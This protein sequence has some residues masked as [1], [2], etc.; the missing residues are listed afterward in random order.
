MEKKS[1]DSLKKEPKAIHRPK[2]L[3]IS[4]IDEISLDAKVKLLQWSTIFHTHKQT[5][6]QTM[7]EIGVKID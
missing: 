7:I 2:V 5:Q 3:L 4:A 1:V 6:V